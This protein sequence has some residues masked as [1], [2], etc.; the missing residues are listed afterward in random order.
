MQF[1]TN[2]KRRFVKQTTQLYFS[3]M[4]NILMK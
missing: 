1:T 2:R 3:K 4:I